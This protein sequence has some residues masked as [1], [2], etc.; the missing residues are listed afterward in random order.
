[1]VELFTTPPS[2]VAIL[3]ERPIASK[4]ARYQAI[5]NEMVTN[6]RQNRVQLGPNARALISLLDGT[7][8][9]NALI[10]AMMRLTLQPEGV[11]ES[12]RREKMADE[13]DRLMGQFRT[14][15]LLVG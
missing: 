14:S 15:A 8:D 1:M 13:V 12:E 2:Y 7:N 10:E 9:R 3:N 4:Y 5:S 11:A 6:Q